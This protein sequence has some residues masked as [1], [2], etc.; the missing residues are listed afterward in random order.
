MLGWPVHC[1]MSSLGRL[2]QVLPLASR[3]AQAPGACRQIGDLASSLPGRG[4]GGGAP[5]E[6]SDSP[7]PGSKQHLE[8]LPRHGSPQETAST[9]SRYSEEVEQPAVGGDTCHS[10]CC[11]SSSLAQGPTAL[12][13]TLL[14]PTCHKQPA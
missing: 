2:R 3:L 10:W 14:A 9:D 7:A 12:G 13:T 6:P 1:A 5:S 11:R 8:R 4:R